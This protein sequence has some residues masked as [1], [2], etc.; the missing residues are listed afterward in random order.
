MI[1]VFDLDGVLS[2]ADT[3][4]AL[5]LARLRTR[6]W[7]VLPVAV[8]ALAAALVPAAGAL[9][10]RCNR[11]V[12][13]IVLS[14]VSEPEYARLAVRTARRLAAR[15]DN[16]RP[17]VL[18]ALRRAFDDGAGIV[19]TATE[20]ELAAAYLEALG[21][22]GMPLLAS[23]FRFSARGPRFADHNVGERKVETL[24]VIHPGAIVDTLYTDSS[25]DLPLARRS[26]RTVLV[27]ARPRSVREFSHHGVPFQPLGEG[28][29]GD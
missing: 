9:R 13:H 6:P 17:D 10:P 21:V 14:G 4:A 19:I 12:V 22:G 27:D 29:R 26:A 23:R 1:T 28:R 25:S 15:P 5:V 16:V 8:L 20:R 3:M 24:E 11:A 2:R 18:A 7:L